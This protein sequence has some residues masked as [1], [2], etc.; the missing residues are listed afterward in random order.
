MTEPLKK[1]LVNFLFCSQWR[2]FFFSKA[3][4]ICVF[5][6]WSDFFLANPTQSCVFWQKCFFLGI[7]DKNSRFY[8]NSLTYRDSVMVIF[9][10][11]VQNGLKLELRTFAVH[12]IL[13]EH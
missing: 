6:L 2:Q 10:F 11:L 3:A 13:M 7:A 8:Q 4:Q 1:A 9:R 5:W 12:K